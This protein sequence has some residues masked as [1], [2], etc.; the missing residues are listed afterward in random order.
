MPAG[1]LFDAPSFILL[2]TM[3]AVFIAPYVLPHLPW[4]SAFLQPACSPAGQQPRQQQRP[5]FP[6]GYTCAKEAPCCQACLLSLRAP[7][8]SRK[9]SDNWTRCACRSYEGPTGDRIAVP[10]RPDA[11]AAAIDAALLEAAPF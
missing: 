2:C 9:L 1:D 5:S 11:H 6:P 8:I 4:P 10:P 7:K 3:S